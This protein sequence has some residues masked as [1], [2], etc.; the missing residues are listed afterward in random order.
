MHT[1]HA[2]S[3]NVQ[4]GKMCLPIC[5]CLLTWLFC[6]TVEMSSCLCDM[7]KKLFFQKDISFRMIQNRV[8][9]VWHQH[10]WNYCPQASWENSTGHSLVFCCGNWQKCPFRTQLMCMTSWTLNQTFHYKNGIHA[11][12]Y[13]QASIFRLDFGHNSSFPLKSKHHTYTA[14]NRWWT[15]AFIL[16]L[17]QHFVLNL[18]FFY[19]YSSSLFH[20]P[21]CLTICL[22]YM[23]MLHAFS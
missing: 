6:L 14:L 18:S 1:I 5:L 2:L 3:N 22:L 9:N 7:S 15:H 8:M 16:L 10:H 19:D 23:C 21:Y 12:T 20:S 11:Q 4:S 13:I 17:L